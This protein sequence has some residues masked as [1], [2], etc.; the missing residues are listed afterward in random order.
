MNILEMVA[1]GMAHWQE[2]YPDHYQ[3]MMRAGELETELE[4]SAIL[5]RK[6]MDA[7]KAQ[8]LSEAEAWQQAR[9]LFL[10]AKPSDSFL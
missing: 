4:S 8:G 5:T 3:S 10:I 9:E 7:L 1:E 2:Y 6:E